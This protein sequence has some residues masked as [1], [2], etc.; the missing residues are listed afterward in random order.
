MVWS[1][2]RD[3]EYFFESDIRSGQQRLPNG[4]TL[5]AESD[6]APSLAVRGTV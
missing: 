5:I 3:D 6:G 2:T 1:Y 4:N